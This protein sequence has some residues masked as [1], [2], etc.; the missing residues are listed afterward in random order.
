MSACLSPP[1][2]DNDQ[3]MLPADVSEMLRVSV[4]T[5]NVWRCTGRYRLPY[6]KVGRSVRYRRSDVEAF[7]ASRTI[8]PAAGLR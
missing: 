7:V 4:G 1:V 3:Y 2:P 6:I 5:L 8:D